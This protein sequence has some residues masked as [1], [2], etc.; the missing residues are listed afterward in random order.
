MYFCICLV[1]ET[2]YL[3]WKVAGG[4]VLNQLFQPMETKSFHLISP[5]ANVYAGPVLGP[6]LDQGRQS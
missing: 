4:K 3:I 6:I 1:S 5:E 2:K